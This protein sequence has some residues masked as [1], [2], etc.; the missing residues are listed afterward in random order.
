MAPGGE[1]YAGLDIGTTSVSCAVID[2]AT[3]G[4]VGTWSRRHHAELKAARPDEHLQDPDRLLQVARDLLEEALAD[5]GPIYGLGVT[6]Q[7]HGIL[8]LDPEGRA[9][10]PLYT[11]LDGRAGRPGP[12][13]VPYHKWLGE[14]VGCTVPVGFGAAT[15]F[16]NVQE[17]AVPSKAR[18]LCGIP[19]YVAMHLAGARFPVTDPT[20]AHGWGL[21]DPSRAD[22]DREA[23]Q[24]LGA[25]RLAL[26]EVAERGRIL[27]YRTG[28]FPTCTPLGDNQASFL[29]SVR[30]PEHSVLVNIGTSGQISFLD[31]LLGPSSP[32]LPALEK[33]PYPGGRWLFVG[34]SLTGG[35]AL[36]SLAALVAEIVQVAT[37]QVLEDPYQVLASVGEAPA[38]PP[39]LVDTRLA[40]S[41]ANP[42]VR[43]S[44]SNISLQNFTLAH[45]VHG[46]CQG[47]VHELYDLWMGAGERLDARLKCLVGSGNALRANHLLREH[48]TATFGKCLYIPA[49]REEA[50]VGAAVHCAAIVR[51]EPVDQVVPRVVTYGEK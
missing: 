38:G 12:N 9:V 36:E 10:S 21:F 16:V 18:A 6:G 46:F 1:R 28:A 19:E 51:G 8:Y 30:E 7:M 15:H 40:G 26:P 37:G 45:L 48:L 29:G 50:A 33:R 27:G 17:S 43:G 42:D 25:P 3:G 23:W 32:A 5:S 31:Q 4:V 2:L 13:G 49:Y 41:R 22:F 35:K 11:W 39:L 47:I 14:Q 24:R 34:A 44:I 20:L